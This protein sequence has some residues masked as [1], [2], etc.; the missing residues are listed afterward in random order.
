MADTEAT[1]ERDSSAVTS[2]VTYYASPFALAAQHVCDAFSLPFSRSVPFLPWQ[3]SDPWSFVFEPDQYR[4][5]RRKSTKSFAS[6]PYL[7]FCLFFFPQL[8][9]VFLN[10]LLP[11]ACFQPFLIACQ[12]W[13]GTKWFLGIVPVFACGNGL[14]CQLEQLEAIAEQLRNLQKKKKKW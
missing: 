2:E 11:L 3:L 6:S 5:Q 4:Q 13:G 9:F 8:T 12:A 7:P 10:C 14:L 1:A